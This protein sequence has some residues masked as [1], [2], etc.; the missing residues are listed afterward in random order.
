MADAVNGRWPGVRFLLA[1]EWGATIDPAE[2]PAPAKRIAPGTPPSPS[3]REEAPLVLVVDDVVANRRV[4]QLMLKHLG[5]RRREGD[6]RHTPIIAMTADTQNSNRESCLKQGMDDFIAKPVRLEVL[7]RVL[8]RWAP[9]PP[10]GPAI[11]PALERPEADRDSPAR[12]IPG[13]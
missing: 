9:M 4:A 3:V 12:D 13:S 5:Y 11:A 10:T 8:A 2:R 6:S 7:A 1:T